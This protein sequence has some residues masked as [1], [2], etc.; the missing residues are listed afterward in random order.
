MVRVARKRK[1]R[2]DKTDA[3]DDVVSVHQTTRR[4]FLRRRNLEA[5]SSATYDTTLDVVDSGHA[6]QLAAPLLQ[7]GVTSIYSLSAPFDS[8][9]FSP[10]YRDYGDST[11]VCSHC[12]ALFWHDERIKKT[13]K[14]K[15]VH[16]HC[17]CKNGRVRLPAYEEPPGALKELLET[18]GFMDNVRAYNQMFS[19]T[20]FGARIDETINDSRS[21]YVFKV[22]EQIYHWIGSLGP[23]PGTRPRFL[24]LYIYE[25][26]TGVENRISHFGGGNS[27]RICEDIVRRLI[28]LLDTH[29]E[30]IRLFSVAGS[31]KH[32]LP[33]SDAI[34]AIVFDTGPRALSDYDVIIHPRSEYPKRVNKLHPSYMSLQ[35]PLM[36]FFGEPGFH[37]DLKLIDAPGSTGSRVR[38]MTMNMFYCYQLHDRLNSY[39]LMMRLGRL[40]Q[41]YVVTVY[42]S[43]E[44]D[45]M[46]YI[47]KKQK[48]IRKDY[49]SGLYDAIS[50]GDQTG[51][52]VGS[53]TI[54]PASFTG[55]PHYMYS[56]YLDALAICRVFGN[57]QFFI[58]FTCNVRWPEIA[59]YLQ[60]FPLLT[61]SDRADIVARVFRFKV[62]Q[63]VAFLKDGKPLGDFRRVLYTI[64]FQKRGLPHCHTLVWLYSSVSSH[65]RERIDDYISAKLPDPRTDLA[66]YAVV[67]ATMMHG[68]CGIPNL[69]AP[70]M[71]GPTCTK[72]FP[73]KYNEKTFFDADGR[74]HY[75]RRNTG[76]YTTR[77]GVH[78]DNSY[79]VPYNR[80]LCM[81][82]QAHINVECC[83]STT[84][85]KY[86][87][88]NISKGTDRIAAR[89]SKSVGSN[90][91]A[92]SQVSQ[93]V[94]EVQN[95]IDSRFICPHE[96]CWH[97]FNFPIHHREPAVQILSVYLENMQLMKLRGKQSL[98]EIIENTEKKKTTLTE[99]LCYN[100]SS[101]AGRHLAYLDFPSEFVWYQ[102]Q[103]RWK[104]RA[105]INKSSIGRMSYIH[106]SFGE[107]FFSRM[108]LCHQKGCTN[109]VDIRT[110][111]QVEY[112]TYRSPCEA[113]GLLGDDKEWTIALEEALASASAF[114]LRSLFAH[115]LVYSEVSNSLALW[116]KHWEM[117]S[118]DIPLRAAASLKM[119]KLHINRDDL[120][121]Y[122]LYEV[123][124][125]LNQCGKT[126]ND[127]ALPSLPDDLLLDL[128]NQ[129]LFVYGHGGTGK[130]FLWKAIITC[131]RAKG[132]IVLA[133]ASSGIASLLLPSSRTA[134]S[135]F[136]LPIDLTDES[137]CNINK[138]T[139]MAKLLES[140]DLIVW[141]EAPMNTKRCFEALDHSLRD[142]LGNKN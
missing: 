4:G 41:Q 128:A 53:R 19:M 88:K 57:P 25:T 8:S 3:T 11:Y 116:E 13:F 142:I 96:A 82:F 113:V 30:L 23:Q 77:S 112:Q 26:D 124:I 83:G 40:F 100:A 79:V 54:L 137:M 38:K 93:L 119:P 122:V 7:H 125:L 15:K 36:F 133:V 66:G 111:N 123:E 44:L 117:M 69:R 70:C 2:D 101:S 74:A 43:I 115:I 81:T 60:P 141:D 10:L 20:S 31:K 9:A 14:D 138:N 132:K 108:L 76:V 85:I 42:C 95:F 104:R 134:H 110:V 68:P 56:H 35:F 121:N 45:R 67:S 50:R 89:I 75:R 109:F 32:S 24:Q 105:N 127:F 12:G 97:I 103:K 94:D 91:R 135:R 80:L 33:T 17:C 18:R 78:F 131:L 130:T 61:A 86:L 59:R 106:P 21:P 71:E 72:N 99:W 140:T 136:K 114:Q 107:A 118:E 87:F 28:V 84:L 65:I 63:F 62:K 102:A 126:L 47:R 1:K 16:Y 55:G 48:D 22:S 73:K 90:S 139:Q 37:T 46:D 29:N 58:T 5:S 64:E 51:S 92:R 27:N 34:G 129:L 6:P 49:L 98:Q 120:H 52:D 39:S